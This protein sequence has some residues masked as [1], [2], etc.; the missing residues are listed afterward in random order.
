MP[1]IDP[2]L[3]RG[4]EIPKERAELGGGILETA[5]RRGP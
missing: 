3:H 5:L 4:F 2:G 1:L